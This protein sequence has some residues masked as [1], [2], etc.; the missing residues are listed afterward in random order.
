MSYEVKQVVGCDDVSKSQL[1]STEN[2]ITLSSSYFDK[3]ESKFTDLS[4]GD[5]SF[6]EVS[7]SEESSSS[8]IVK[9]NDEN[10]VESVRISGIEIPKLDVKSIF[11]EGNILLLERKD[12][13]VLRAV[14]SDV[15]EDL[16]K[17]VARDIRSLVEDSSLVILRS[18]WESF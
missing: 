12:G 14:N 11:L 2:S 16:I 15:S 1:I 13:T 3:G 4:I 6:K 10:E 17:K 18:R 7:G 9:F 8:F 5:S